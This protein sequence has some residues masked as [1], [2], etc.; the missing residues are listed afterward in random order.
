MYGDEEAT[1]TR[2]PSEVPPRRCG[3]HG[4]TLVELLIVIV[5]LGILSGIAVFGVARFRQDATTSACGA[6]LTTVQR[7]ATAYDASTGNWPAD[8]DALVTGKYLKSAPTATYRFDPT[9]KTVTRDPACAAGTTVA[10]IG[11]DGGKCL[12]LANSS[13]AD[14]TAVQLGTCDGGAVQRWAAP[15]SWPGPITTLGKCLDVTGGGT[16]NRTPVQLN[17]CN[18]SGAQQWNSEPGRILRNPQS[19]RCLDAENAT[20]TDGT[21]IIIWDCHGAANQQWVLG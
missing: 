5:V 15:A 13:G 11:G 2:R 16:A 18:G 21:R 1:V 14:G 8:I 4:F 7:A 9:A 12:D 3:Q 19:G 20:T 6:E 17:T 10:A